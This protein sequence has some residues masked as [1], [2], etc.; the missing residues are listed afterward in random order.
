MKARSER[1][2]YRSEDCAIS[3]GFVTHSFDALGLYP[4][5]LCIHV[6]CRIFEFS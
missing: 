6:N 1:D 2:T 4:V 3:R 5:I